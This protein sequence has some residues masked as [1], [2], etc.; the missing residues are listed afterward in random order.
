MMLSSMQASP[1]AA[2]SGD[3]E[4]DGPARGVLS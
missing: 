1:V 4:I 2:G 3:C